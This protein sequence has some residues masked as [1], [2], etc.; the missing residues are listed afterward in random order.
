MQL[1]CRLLVVIFLDSH[2]F[3]LNSLHESTLSVHPTTGIIFSALVPFIDY[4]VSRN[5]PTWDISMSRRKRSDKS[6][7]AN[8]RQYYRR[9]ESSFWDLRNAMPISSSLPPSLDCVVRHYVV[10]IFK[11]FASEWER[12]RRANM[13]ISS[14]CT[15]SRESSP[16]TL[17]TNMPS[18]R[19]TIILWNGGLVSTRHHGYPV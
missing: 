11:N 7:S 16:E 12:V 14:N 9:L 15:K 4:S 18:S 13:R 10:K 17:T 1:Q 2:L 19:S 8:V 3:P 5:I 6:N